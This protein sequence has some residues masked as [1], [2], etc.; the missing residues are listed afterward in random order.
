MNATYLVHS[1]GFSCPAT[2]QFTWDSKHVIYRQIGIAVTATVCPLIIFLNMLV[3]VAVK[4]VK[5]LQKG[6]NILIASLAMADLSVGSLSIPLAISL[7]ALFLQ[8]NAP[9]NII[10][11]IRMISVFL[12]YSASAIPVATSSL[13]DFHLAVDVISSL[14]WFLGMTLMVYFYSMVCIET[15]KRRKITIR[16]V[17][18][19][20]KACNGRRIAFTVFLL[21]MAVLISTG[22]VVVFYILARFLPFW[23]SSSVLRVAETFLQ[24]NSLVNPAIYFYRNRQCRKAAIRILRFGI[25]HTAEPVVRKELRARRKFDFIACLDVGERM[26]SQRATR[27]RQSKALAVKTHRHRYSW[28][29]VSV[30]TGVKMERRNSAPS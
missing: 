21:T 7:D 13:F 11:K 2:P 3:I 27:L 17:N 28:C 18:S 25:P 14:V 22:V 30:S 9:E 29:G 23:S 24:L 8:G 20:I 1:Y 26:G 12:M 15:R 19:L 6:S 5:E 10:C 16:R 4:K